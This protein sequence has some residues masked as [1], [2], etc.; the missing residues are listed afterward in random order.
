MCQHTQTLPGSGSKIRK[1]ICRE[2]HALVTSETTDRALESAR[3]EGVDERHRAEAMPASTYT[4]APDIWKRLNGRTQIPPAVPLVLSVYKQE[5]CQRKLLFQS[6]YIFVEEC[7]IVM[8]PRRA[9]GESTVVESLLL[10]CSR[11]HDQLQTF[12]A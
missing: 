8:V 1:T 9:H 4:D 11:Q 5:S 6:S 12:R 10:L 7:T 2:I 3:H